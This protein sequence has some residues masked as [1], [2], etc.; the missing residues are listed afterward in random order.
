MLSIMIPAYN[1]ES[2]LFDTVN[3]L[4]NVANKNNLML[5]IIIVNDGSS[6]NTQKIIDELM[7]NYQFIKCITNKVNLGQGRSLLK[8]LEIAK[9][10]KLLIVA[11][12]G[13]ISDEDLSNLFQ[14]INKAEMI[15]L[16]FLNRELRG[17]F[18]SII[19]MLYNIFH[20][21]IFNVYIQ[22]VSGPC[23]YPMEK[24]KKI[25]IN[26]KRSNFV[27][28]ITIKLLLQGSTYHEIAGKMQRGKVGSTG[29]SIK[30]LLDVIISFLR[31]FFDIKLIHRDL[32]SKF[33]KRIQ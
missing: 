8:V 31:L 17:R 25:R 13:D 14:N 2:Y 29:I 11:G 16:Y 24:L 3:N 15:F 5:D 7:K 1:E 9:G 33:P 12:D 20:L 26:S 4:I 19:S 28:E 22:Y 32:Y 21:L 30:N 23:I 6:D 27:A 18:R 10:N